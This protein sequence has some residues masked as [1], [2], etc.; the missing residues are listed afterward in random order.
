MANQN[1]LK[2]I[3]TAQ[4]LAQKQ[5]L[6]ATKSIK[7]LGDQAV[8]S[9]KQAA[10]ALA[11]IGIAAATGVGIAVKEFATFEKQMSN[12]KAITGAAG[13]E[14]EDLTELAKKM[15]RETAFTAK[16]AGDAMQFLGMAGF[17]TNEIMDSL[18][19]T[20]DLAAAS[21]LSLGESAD[22]MSNVLSG[23][24]AEAKDANKF[25][26]VLAKTITTSNTNMVELG[27]AMK[28]LAP[29]AA[30]LGVSLEETSA[31]IGLLANAGLKGG[32]ATRQLAGSLARL[33]K[34]TP[35]M[36]GA[37]KN[38]NLELFNAEGNFVGLIDTVKQMEEGM[39]DF[40]QEQ[41]LATI[42]TVFGT[43]SV[44][45]MS[46]LLAAGSEELERYTRVL[47]G[48][49]GTARKMAET[50]LDNLAGSF[51]LMKSALSG[52]LID[53]GAKF[54]PFLKEAI[55]RF[56]D[57]ILAITEGMPNLDEIGKWFSENVDTIKMVG[58]AIVGVL[59]PAI[60]AATVAF[61]SFL[62]TIAPWAAL[63]ALVA[64]K[65]DEI[66]EAVSAAIG[67]LKENEEVAI[68]LAS[69]ITVL[70]M[71]A[72]ISIATAIY[73]NIIPAIVAMGVAA[74]PWLLAGAIVGGL[75]AGILLIINNWDLLKKKAAELWE[76]IKAIWTNGLD[77]IT[78]AWLSAWGAMKSGLSTVWQGILGI[79]ESSINVAIRGINKLINAMNTISPKQIS[80]IGTAALTEATKVQNKAALGSA[81]STAT[82]ANI[83]FSNGGIVPKYFANGGMAR[84]TDTVPA[85]LTPGEVVL[86]AAQQNQLARN[87]QGN[88]VNITVNANINDQSDAN[89]LIEELKRQMELQ[90]QA[91]I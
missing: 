42:A 82:G 73:S 32:V 41:K 57:F 53:V 81:L 44:K 27:E 86:N 36:R 48:A 7:K 9:S 72:L 77:T 76:A 34:A 64:L 4:N 5:I 35:K 56:T 46:I 75:V 66:S 24:G 85:M 2:I 89:F 17:E 50:Q 87:L 28:F 1:E 11:G 39:A 15:G 70:L 69:A 65:F 8:K 80:V 67:W 33:A 18:Q 51:T 90:S 13:E 40:T 16:E 84:G 37:M 30:T 52:F 10:K 22:I 23:F 78:N 21:G 43:G 59:T 20:M 68:G 61:S 19:G 55:G 74:A 54:S 71:P 88:T 29:T 26:D 91:S 63:G 31:T 38:A 47:E 12:V 62:L 25:V 45:Q 49:E 3:I 14:F 6:S 79:I 83:A 58:G 60:V